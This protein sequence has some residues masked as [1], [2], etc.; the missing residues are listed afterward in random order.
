MDKIQFQSAKL[1]EAMQA[2]PNDKWRRAV[3]A[4]IEGGGGTL[5][6]ADKG[7]TT[8]LRAAGFRGTAGSLRVSAHRFFQD[9]RVQAALQEEAR[10]RLVTLLPSALRA[11]EQIMADPSH[12]DRLQA[13]RSVMD[14]GGLHVVTEEKKTLEITFGPAERARAVMLARRLNIPLDQLV[15]VRAA[16]QI[17]AQPAQD[18]EFEEAADE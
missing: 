7:Y 10:R 15:G 11:H 3:I 8:A 6:R 18:A 13:A 4:Y 14:R 1:G 17:A 9:A 2:L 12:K 5:G 16:K